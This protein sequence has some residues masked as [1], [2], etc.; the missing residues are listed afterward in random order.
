MNI[1]NI[2]INGIVP[3]IT[4]ENKSLKVI[5]LEKLNA[6]T[7]L[8]NIVSN[9]IYFNYPFTTLE[10]PCITYFEVV[11]VDNKYADNKSNGSRRLFQVDIWSSKSSKS[12]T[13]LA[14]II[15]KL[16]LE[17]DFE[18]LSQTDMFHRDMQI[19]RKLMQFRK[20]EVML[21]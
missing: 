9:R 20:N 19:Y 15:S 2:T 8:T 17:L 16:M 14:N 4:V 10:L 1:S 6:S 5:I 21:C 7:A 12:T 13:Y 18:K 3:E 11:S